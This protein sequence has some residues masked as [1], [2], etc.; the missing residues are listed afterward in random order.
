MW[1]KLIKCRLDGNLFDAPPMHGHDQHFKTRL[2]IFLPEFFALFFI[3]WVETFDFSWMGWLGNTMLTKQ[4]MASALTPVD[5]R[6]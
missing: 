2:E 4:C 1:I 5:T 6:V 3:H